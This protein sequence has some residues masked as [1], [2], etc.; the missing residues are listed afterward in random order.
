MTL[1]HAVVEAAST[2]G[3]RSDETEDGNVARRRARSNRRVRQD[4][5]G[6]VV[7]F[8]EAS[9]AS[10]E[11]EELAMEIGVPTACGTQAH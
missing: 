3:G 7:V 8:S 9:A 4:A 10:S 11:P 6:T 2:Y 5:G 1:N